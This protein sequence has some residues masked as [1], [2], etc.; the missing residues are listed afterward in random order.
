M[1]LQPSLILSNPD[2]QIVLRQ[3]WYDSMPGV[4]G[5]HEEGGFVVLDNDGKLK[6]RPWPKGDANTILVPDHHGCI[7][8]SQEIVA[9]FHTH[10]NIGDDYLQEP[11]E[12]DIRAVRDDVH[13]KAA[14]YQGEFV[15]S[16]AM[17]YLIRPNGQV[18]ELGETNEL[19]MF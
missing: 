7:I 17:V 16:Q 14:N 12:T 11:S 3:A 8:D 19:L 2:V 5:G 13:L 15:I 4:S 6:V 18:R 9:S 1:K 10:S